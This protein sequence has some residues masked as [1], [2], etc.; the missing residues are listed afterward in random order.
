MLD[1]P[2]AEV[3]TRI[4]GGRRGD[5]RSPNYMTAD[6]SARVS[7]AFSARGLASF[8]LVAFRIHGA[9]TNDEILE[10]IWTELRGFVSYDRVALALIEEDRNTLR[11]IAF[12]SD[13]PSELKAGYSCSIR[14]SVLSPGIDCSE[15]RII[16]DFEEHRLQTIPWPPEEIMFHEGMRSSL[17]LPLIV[18]NVPTGIMHFASR[19]IAAFGREQAAMLREPVGCVANA[20]ERRRLASALA[21]QTQELEA[22]NER[23][24]L[25]LHRLQQEVLRET[26][27][28]Q[29][30][31][32]RA[33]MLLRIARA[34]TA[35]ED[36]A[37]IFR[38]T[39]EELRRF[40]RFDRA[41]IALLDATGENLRFAAFEP[42]GR[43]IFGRDD[44]APAASSAA[45]EAIRNR[46]TA[47]ARDLARERN[48]YE[49]ELLHQ[50]GIR[51]YVFT[52]LLLHGVAIGTLNAGASAPDAFSEDDVALLAEA[53]KPIT[54]AVAKLSLA[55]RVGR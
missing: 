36:I 20:I 6:A 5:S 19:S 27:E 34:I 11:W 2:V 18:N 14:A 40:L 31:R 38:V 25:A 24:A 17:V 51:S 50:A 41:S 39:V 13:A 43:D 54:I 52:P 4:E 9:S 49:D 45:G 30:S 55:P 7:D 12:R 47:I 22:A 26:L 15:M 48:Y 1:G 44:Q 29:R 28:L 37:A 33:Q 35:S 10:P 23:K 32:D 3:N 53:A 16:E 42:A 46:K 21:A 8:E